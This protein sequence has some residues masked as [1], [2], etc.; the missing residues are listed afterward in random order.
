MSRAPLH[1]TTV[2]FDAATWTD[3]CRESTRLSVPRATYI[4]EA[5][6]ARI[7]RTPTCLELHDLGA[8]LDAAEAKLVAIFEAGR[9]ARQRAEQTG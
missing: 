5:T 7:A 6:Q 2:R 3:V 1:T 8:R 4:R 9:R